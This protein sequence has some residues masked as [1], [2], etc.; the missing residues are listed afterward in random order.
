[1]TLLLFYVGLALGI[2]FLCSVLEAVLLSVTP[3]F[4]AISEQ[5][6]KGYAKRLRGYKHQIDR[7]LSAILSLNTIAHTVGAAGAGAQAAIVFE[8]VSVGVISGAL[9][10]AILIFSEI[11]PKTLGALHWK[12]LVAPVVKILEPIILVM[13]PLVKL[14][15]GIAKLLS[16]DVRSASTS[17]A[18]LAA[19]AKLGRDEG[20]LE[21]S[22]SRI[23]VSLFRFSS[24]N[25]RAI[26]TPRTVL[27]ALSETETVESVV[28]QHGEPRFSRIPIY[29]KDLDDITGYV[30]KQ[31]VLLHAARGKMNTQL[32]ELRRELT[33]VPDTLKLPALL[34]RLLDTREHLALVCDEFGGTS[35]IVCMEDLIETLLGLEIMDEVDSTEDM[36]QLAREQWQRRAG[37]LGLVEDDESSA[38]SAGPASRT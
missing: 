36:Q 32:V 13:W 28:E 6:G 31:D 12:R 7:P 30:L 21:E 26:M 5:H 11:I 27:F 22:E 19:L 33:I 8:N 29:A 18:E 24:L 35:G 1:M 3:S 34:E 20:V 37:R 23:L 14:S 38:E 25:A 10:L 16:S 15:E 17:R 4:V 2:S 9:T